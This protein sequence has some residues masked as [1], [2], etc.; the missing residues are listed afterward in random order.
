MN[1]RLLEECVEELSNGGFSLTCGGE[2]AILGGMNTRRVIIED[3]LAELAKDDSP[4]PLTEGIDID[5]DRL[6]V[7][8]NPTHENNVD[9]SLDGNPTVDDNLIPGVPVWSIFKRKQH[10]SGWRVDGNPLAYA[11]KG[12][13]NWRFRSPN[14]QEAIMGQFNAIAD[15]FL[16]EHPS[17][18]VT[19]IVPSSN[20][21]NVLIANTILSKAPNIEVIEGLVCKLTTEEVY[22]FVMMPN[23]RFRAF[24]KNKFDLAIQEL[25]G[26]LEEMDKTKGGVF[27]R[28][29]VADQDMRNAIDRTIKFS[30]TSKAK[31]V[32]KINGSDLL[33]IDDV[34][35]RGQ[36]IQEMVNLIRESYAPKS[37]TALTLFSQCYDVTGQ[38][39]VERRSSSKRR[40]RRKRRV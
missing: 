15:K 29:S 32:D 19:I 28:H 34:V 33:I 6:V 10:I 40:R 30:P 12:E 23:S 39:P 26:Y 27:V 36:T 17:Y 1:R 38:K 35:S 4:V 9:T 7:S 13:L 24:Y 21:L 16:R 5:R 11:L 2:N 25:E 31:F 18:G 37:I 22:N 3:A 14:D 8:Y 20:P